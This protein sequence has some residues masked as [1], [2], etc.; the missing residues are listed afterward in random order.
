[1]P[2]PNQNQPKIGVYTDGS[3]I[4]CI[5]NVSPKSNAMGGFAVYFPGG[6]FASIAEKYTRHPTNQRCELM[7][8]YRAIQQSL[9][10]IIGGDV[11]Q[12]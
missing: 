8:I 10:Y 3:C 9:Q 11:V 5:N 6:E 1:M 2:P 12:L 4:S 7:A